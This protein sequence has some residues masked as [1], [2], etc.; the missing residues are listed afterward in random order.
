MLINFLTSIF[1]FLLQCLITLCKVLDILSIRCRLE[2]QVFNFCCCSLRW[3]SI[4]ISITGTETA[5][6]KSALVLLYVYIRYIFFVA[7]VIKCARSQVSFRCLG[8]EGPD[9]SGALLSLVE[10]S[11]SKMGSKFDLKSMVDQS[12]A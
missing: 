3:F 4:S 12:C 10:Y 1:H 11:W 5:Q 8:Y 7:F 6:V 9:P 2:F